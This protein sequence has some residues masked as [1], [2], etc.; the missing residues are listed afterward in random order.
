MMY[1]PEALLRSDVN[2]ERQR[3]LEMIARIGGVLL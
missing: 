1:L 2:E 3:K